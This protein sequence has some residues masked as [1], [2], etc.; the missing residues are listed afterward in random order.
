MASAYPLQRREVRPR[1]GINRP[2]ALLTA[3]MKHCKSTPGPS[4]ATT[5]LQIVLQ[6]F[7]DLGPIL[8]AVYLAR[9]ARDRAALV[10]APGTLSAGR[11][12]CRRGNTLLVAAARC[13]IQ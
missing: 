3:N 8:S 4:A 6:A 12:Q 2:V 10:G 9:R 7:F 5:T 1:G 11:L 13:R